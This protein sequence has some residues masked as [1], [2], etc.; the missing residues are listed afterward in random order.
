MLPFPMLG[1]VGSHRGLGVG[2]QPRVDAMLPTMSSSTNAGSF[3]LAVRRMEWKTWQRSFYEV[4]AWDECG[5]K[6]RISLT[7]GVFSNW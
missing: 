6:S 1:C 4:T 3:R 5:Q 2:F 7:F